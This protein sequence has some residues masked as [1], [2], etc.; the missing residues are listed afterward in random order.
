[1]HKPTELAQ[2]EN[3]E[4]SQNPNKKS[5]SSILSFTIFAYFSNFSARLFIP[6]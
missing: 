2:S 6:I 5:N 3:K 1:M 4:P